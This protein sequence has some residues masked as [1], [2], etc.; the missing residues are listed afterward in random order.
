MVKMKL[1]SL[2]FLIL[3]FSSTFLV[4]YAYGATSEDCGLFELR[5]GCDLSGWM[6]LIMGD[7]AIGAVLA[8]LLHHLSHRSNVKIEEN[9]AIAKENSKNIQKIIVAQEESRNRRKIYVVQTLKNHFSSIL[10]CIGII[11]K[12]MM[13]SNV[14]DTTSTNLL[15]LKQKDSELK[16]LVY[17]SRS[18]LD[19]SID[20]FD[21][22][23]IDQI[24]KFFT[25]IDQLDLLNI[26]TN[27]FPNYDEI[28]E[29]IFQLTKRL[30]DSLESDVV[31]K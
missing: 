1:F 22:L 31:L 25:S 20:L 29:K 26:K 8:I 7:L 6:K 14:H 17:R 23:F 10:L 28:K 5:S 11:N 27:R 3:F 16:N 21:P 19:L 2:I 15:E 24:E 13:E 18:T 9:T 4:H 30:N 12:F